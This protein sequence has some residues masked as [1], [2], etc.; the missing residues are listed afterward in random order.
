[1]TRAI[2]AEGDVTG[3][4]GRII[5]SASVAIGAERVTMFRVDSATNTLEVMVSKGR[6]D[7]RHSLFRKLNLPLDDNSMAGYVAK[8]R[9]A[10]RRAPAPSFDA[11]SRR[12]G[13]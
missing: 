7:T 11:P 9:G 10:A 5:E 2:S 13:A 6:R 8:V 1:M 12:P 4:A 3:A